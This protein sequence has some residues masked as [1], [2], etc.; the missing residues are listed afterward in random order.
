MTDDEI[1]STDGSHM[2]TLFQFL[3]RSSALA[4]GI[5]AT[6]CLLNG[7]SAVGDVQP[8]DTAPGAEHAVFV[9]GVEPPGVMVGV[10]PGE[11]EK[12][13]RFRPSPWG[14][15]SIMMT[16]RGYVVLRMPANR[17]VGINIVH[18]KRSPDAAL[19]VNYVPCG[20]TSTPVISTGPGKVLYIGHANYRVA[21]DGRLEVNY[22]ERFELAQAHLDEHFPALKGKLEQAKVQMLKTTESCTRTVIVPIYR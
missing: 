7:C 22:R 11:I 1:L 8:S 4:L 17:D 18:V 15:G 14:G 12:D 3:R 10:M 6:A 16:N 19:G 21:G 20:E 9:M 13:Y 5:L 2:S